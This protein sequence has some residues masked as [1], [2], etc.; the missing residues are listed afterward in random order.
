[1]IIVNFQTMVYLE[2]GILLEVKLRY[3]IYLLN[4]LKSLQTQF[5]LYMLGLGYTIK[6]YNIFY[7]IPWY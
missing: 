2:N 4:L 7:Q 1:M 5:I 3:I 6:Y